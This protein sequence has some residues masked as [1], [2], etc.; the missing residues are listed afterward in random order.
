MWLPK[1]ERKMLIQYYG[2]L[3]ESGV[4]TRTRF[5][6]SELVECLSGNDMRN[7]VKVASKTLQQR[8]LLAFLDD[9][10]DALSVQLSL[11]GYDLGRE[12]CSLWL[13]I[14][15]WYLEYIKNHPIWVIISFLGGVFATLLVQWLS[16]VII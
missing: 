13:L 6:L 11:E 16:K 4:Q 1:D 12:Y 3:H 8:N 15:L 9:R 10:G 5:F 2:R 7:R 14:K